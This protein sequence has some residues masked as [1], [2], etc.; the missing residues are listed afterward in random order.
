MKSKASSVNQVKDYNTELIINALKTVDSGTKNTVSQ[1][2]GLS[3]ATCNT[4]LN[5]L[6][7]AKRVI[8]V[9]CDVPA[10]G[11][12]PKSYQFNADF[13]HICCMYFTFENFNRVIHYTI[14]NLLGDN[15]ESQELEMDYIDSNTI[16]TVIT[17]LMSNDSLISKVSVGFEGYLKE[18][19][20]V[21]SGIPE[22]LDCPLKQILIDQFGIEVHCDNDMNIIALGLFRQLAPQSKDPFVA[23]G[24]FKGRCPGAGTI[25]YQKIVKGMSNFAGE[26]MLLSGCGDDFWTDISQHYEKAVSTAYQIVLSY[27]TT[28]NPRTIVL[29]GLNASGDMLKRIKD[30]CSKHLHE[31]HIP[32]LLFIENIKEYYI[33]GLFQKTVTYMD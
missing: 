17:D 16:I 9:E 30:A 11:R 29:T 12:P 7:E 33:D 23:I 5:E 13:A 4:I 14:V 32:E 26:V 22:L 6:S 28:I 21:S 24:L 1:M 3:I 18:G 20:I 2:T 8:E 19:K 27:I 10:A 25:V 15:L 31:E